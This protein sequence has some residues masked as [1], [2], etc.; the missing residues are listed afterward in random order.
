VEKRLAETP[1]EEFLRRFWGVSRFSHT[2]IHFHNSRNDSRNDSGNDTLKLTLT[3]PISKSLGSVRVSFNQLF[4]DS[5][6]ESFLEILK[7]GRNEK[8]LRNDVKLLQRSFC[9]VSE[10]VSPAK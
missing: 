9:V 7:R 5:F 4:L 2:L 3:D 10:V 1:L 8:R 6:L